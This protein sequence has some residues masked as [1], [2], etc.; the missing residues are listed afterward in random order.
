MLR[1]DRQLVLVQG[2]APFL[3]SPRTTASYRTVPL[4]RVIVT[5]LA[6]H[7]AAFPALGQQVEC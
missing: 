3:G 7:L 2:G 5:A 6:A 4:P 1:V